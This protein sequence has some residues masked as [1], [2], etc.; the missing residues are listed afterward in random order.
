MKPF[1][2][3]TRWKDKTSCTKFRFPTK[4]TQAEIHQKTDM[5]EICFPRRMD[6][7]T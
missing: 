3:E 4:S 5:L 6:S 2:E 7:E 1:K